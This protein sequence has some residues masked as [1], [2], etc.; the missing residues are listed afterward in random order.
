MVKRLCRWGEN[1]LVAWVKY[2]Q[3]IYLSMVA[4]AKR[5]FDRLFISIKRCIYTSLVVLEKNR[6]F[7]IAKMEDIYVCGT[8]R[9]KK[10]FVGIDK[11]FCLQNFR[12]PW[13]FWRERGG[14]QNFWMVKFSDCCPFQKL[15]RP[16][17]LEV[18]VQN[19]C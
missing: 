10:N 2:L 9:V 15:Q 11:T 17:Y 13:F 14:R 3:R 7:L 6:W 4:G 19:V 8:Q 1:I 18:N 16:K 5:L 12:A